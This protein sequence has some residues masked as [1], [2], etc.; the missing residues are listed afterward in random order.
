MT[1]TTLGISIGEAIPDRRLSSN[2]YSGTL[3][4]KGKRVR[5]DISESATQALSDRDEP[6]LVELEL[7]FSCLVRKQIRFTA[8]QQEPGR[9]SDCTRVMEGLYASFRTV[10]T[11]HCRIDET[12]GKPP[13]ETLPVKKPDLFVPDW[14]KLDFRAG[15]WLGEYGFKNDL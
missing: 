3:Q 13:V 8:L 15:R 14:L 1:A 2:A 6:L 11:A 7:Y 4:L 9:D 5:I 10:T 12:D